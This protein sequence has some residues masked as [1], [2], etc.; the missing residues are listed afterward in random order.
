LFLAAAKKI[1]YQTNRLIAQE[2]AVEKSSAAPDERND[3]CDSDDCDEDSSDCDDLGDVK[4][5]DR[6]TGI[7]PMKG[8]PRFTASD[9]TLVPLVDGSKAYAY[10]TSFTE[11]QFLFYVRK[12]IDADRDVQVPFLT[13]FLF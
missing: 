4:P 1:E 7:L 11:T 5:K 13:L 9:R 3:S 10:A 12:T 2:A 6:R 8:N